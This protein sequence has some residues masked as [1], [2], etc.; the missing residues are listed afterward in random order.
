MLFVC[1]YLPTVIH[2]FQFKCP[3]CQKWKKKRL[4]YEKI[5][6]ACEYQQYKQQHPSTTSTSS[7]L[8]T[9]VT[10]PPPRITPPLFTRPQGCIDQL[11]DI[12]RSAIVVYANDNHSTKEISNKI[13]CSEKTVKLWENRWNE[14]HLLV[15]ADRSGRPRIT[16]D[17]QD[18]DIGILSNKTPTKTPKDIKNELHIEA[19][20]HTVS[21]RLD[22]IGLYGCVQETEH[23]LDEFDIQRRLAFC[24]EYIDWTEEQWKNE[25]FTDECNFYLG[26]GPRIYVRRPVGASHDPKYM[27]Q[28]N[29]PH[30][31][32]SLWACICSHGLGH[33]EI[34]TGSLDSTR[35]RNILKHKLI[36]SL[37]QFFPQGPWCLQQD[38]VRFHTT[39]ETITYL[40]NQGITLIEWPPWSPDL[41]PIE[42]LWNVLKAHVYARFPQTLE[43]LNKFIIEEYSKI[44][45]N[46]ISTICLSMPRRLQLV[47][48]N[49]GHKI[50]Y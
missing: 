24:N 20:P 19:S 42:N 39:P 1:V 33:T 12:E 7:T 2:L 28:L 14:T 4:N 29:H 9:T 25:F 48:D 6:S 11:S 10:S 3:S 16:T 8:T 50:A 5:C 46:F 22:E 17:D 15:D 43:E 38:N 34:Y 49:K 47:L 27:Q 18:Q 41:N 44:D 21:R 30:G 32:I 36:P 31:K 26:Q 13:H 37:K 35:H 45:L 40:H 23:A